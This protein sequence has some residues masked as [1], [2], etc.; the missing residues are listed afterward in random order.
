M[1]FILKGIV[2]QEITIMSLFTHIRVLFFFVEYKTEIFY[3]WM[4]DIL[5]PDEVNGNHSC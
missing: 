5:D 1:F 4:S 3:S 2:H